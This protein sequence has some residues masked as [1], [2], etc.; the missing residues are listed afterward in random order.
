MND[1]SL[2]GFSTDASQK[3]KPCP[4]CELYADFL[5]FVHFYG[6]ADFAHQWTAAAL[7]GTRTYFDSSA[8]DFASVSTEARAGTITS[9]QLISPKDCCLTNFI[10]L[11]AA[12]NKALVTMHI[13]PF[14]IQE[15]E[16]AV[17][18]CK[19]TCP[20]EGCS[21]SG[22]RAVDA[23]AAYYFGSLEDGNGAGKLMHHLADL[24]CI[25]FKTCGASGDS[26]KGRAKAN[27]EILNNLQLM[28]TNI[29]NRACTDARS[30]KDHIT[31]WIKVTLIQGTL[32]YAY[33]RQQNTTSAAD[34]ANGAAYAASIVPFISACS[35]TDAEIISN[36]LEITARHTDFA[37]VKTTF[38]RQ[39]TCLGIK[40]KDV[41]GYWDQSQKTYNDGA[42]MCTF[43]VVLA[44]EKESKTKRPYW[45]VFGAVLP[46]IV[47]V[48]CLYRRM[49]QTT[50]KKSDKFRESDIDF[51]DSSDDDS[52]GGGFRIS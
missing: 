52:D 1:R 12:I 16:E 39:Y 22:T 38:E 15:M 5:R 6:K 33:L 34:M 19:S 42:E 37:L 3:M 11:V 23:A 40:C 29:T 21:E 41:G 7:T 45:V 4:H 24:E 17:K 32:H 35:F 27:I 44:E 2:L 46:M 13:L 36:N 48:L 9:T 8:A 30:H 26:I 18:E 14:V 20:K 51:S 25:E 10:S 50:K 47:I 31:K 43:D 49:H 28:Q